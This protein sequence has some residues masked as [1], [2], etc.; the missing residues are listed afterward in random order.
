MMRRPFQP[1][2]LLTLISD[3]DGSTAMRLLAEE[4]IRNA[5]LAAGRQQGMDEGLRLGREEGIAAARAEAER[6]LQA[7]LSRRGEQGAAAAAAALETLLA[8]RQAD[9]AGLDAELRTALAAALEAMFPILLAHAV[10]GE[11]AALLSA[12]LTERGAD[13]LILRAHPDTLATAQADGFPS[14]PFPE[15]RLRLLPDP[16]MPPGRAEASWADGGLVYDPA[17]LKAQVLAI[18]GAPASPASPTLPEIRP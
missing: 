17:A 14:L 2:S 8:Q 13:H 4:R 16:A 11:V 3:E 18:L 5:A 6:G 10:G 12:A 1:P 15:E 9:R 7:E